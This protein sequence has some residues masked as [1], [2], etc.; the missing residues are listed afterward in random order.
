MELLTKNPYSTKHY[1]LLAKKVIV[2]K[3]LSGVTE[4]TEPPMGDFYLL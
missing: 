1:Y 2:A 4:H 3:V